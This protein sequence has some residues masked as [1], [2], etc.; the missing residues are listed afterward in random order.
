MPYSDIN[1]TIIVLSNKG[2]ALAF[3]LD[4]TQGKTYLFWSPFQ[5]EV[6]EWIT[7]LKKIKFIH[8]IILPEKNNMQYIIEP[9]QSYN[10][11]NLTVYIKY[12][13]YSKN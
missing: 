2:N 4:S 6:L 8:S 7:E 12:I 1:I 3:K 11:T 13:Y 10:E 5:K 9:L